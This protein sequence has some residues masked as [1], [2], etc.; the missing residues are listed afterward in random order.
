[1]CPPSVLASTCPS[2]TKTLAPSSSPACSGTRGQAGGYHLRAAL[3]TLLSSH[4]SRAGESLV[5]SLVQAVPQL[6]S[7]AQEPALCGPRERSLP[8]EARSNPHPPVPPLRGLCVPSTP[9]LVDAPHPRSSLLC[10]HWAGTDVRGHTPCFYPDAG[11][12]MGFLLKSFPQAAE[13]PP[14]PD[15]NLR[16]FSGRRPRGPGPPSSARDRVQ[17]GQWRFSGKLCS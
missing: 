14:L 5:L 13:H 16:G 17:S 10:Q 11:P 15:P 1:M 2:L 8:R 3:D 9:R 6:R 12:P 4:G 7:T